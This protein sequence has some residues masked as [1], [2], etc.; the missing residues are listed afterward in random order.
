MRELCTGARC[1]NAGDDTLQA[2]NYYIIYRYSIE[3]PMPTAGR[4]RKAHGA[5]WKKFMCFHADSNVDDGCSISSPALSA[6]RGSSRSS[7][8]QSV[9][10]SSMTS[11]GSSSTDVNGS[12]RLF[13]LRSGRGSSEQEK[14]KT[15]KRGKG[16][17]N[18]KR[19]EEKDI[20]ELMAQSEED[21]AMAAYFGS[22]LAR[23]PSSVSVLTQA[24]HAAAIELA[25][26]SKASAKARSRGEEEEE[27]STGAVLTTASWEEDRDGSS[28]T[29][30]ESEDDGAVQRIHNRGASFCRV[31]TLSLVGDNDDLETF[32][33]TP[34]VETSKEIK[35]ES[36]YYDSFS[37]SHTDYS[38]S[39][40]ENEE[41]EENKVA[42]GKQK[43]L[44]LGTPPR[45]ERHNIVLPQTSDESG[46]YLSP[47]KDADKEETRRINTSKYDSN[48]HSD[49][50]DILNQN[51]D[52][53]NGPKLQHRTS[54]PPALMLGAKFAPSEQEHAAESCPKQCDMRNL[55]RSKTDVNCEL[56]FEKAYDIMADGR[57]HLVQQPVMR[58][59]ASIPSLSGRRHRVIIRRP[60]A[61]I[62]LS[63][64]SED[65]ETSKQNSWVKENGDVLSIR[66]S[67]RNLMVKSVQNTVSTKLNE[68]KMCELVSAKN[69]K[70]SKLSRKLSGVYQGHHV[71]LE[72]LRQ[73]MGDA[74]LP[75]N[76]LLSLMARRVF[77]SQGVMMGRVNSDGRVSM[78]DAQG[79]SMH[80]LS[81]DNPDSRD[82]AGPSSRQESG[83]MTPK[84]I[85]DPIEDVAHLNLPKIKTKMEMQ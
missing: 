41:S 5:A 85:D 34:P 46:A 48:A 35:L 69:P 39:T 40:H 20:G 55:R 62:I 54:A 11:R 59:N 76:D 3:V 56:F 32:A 70:A 65:D 66:S 2:T 23:E 4:G 71:R 50:G 7:N 17:N 68:Y 38:S 8:V 19:K 75:P 58:R 77:S 52:V 72:K 26:E 33:D 82:S 80:T 47:A 78:L 74:E 29:I 9:T 60:S 44:L 57:K 1:E 18:P 16:K 67:Y 36:G 83:Y 42:Y 22:G 28:L 6:T 84:S 53:Q 25:L 64:D 24:A 63:S 73:Q 43:S 31:T 14:T 10:V 81:P 49:E 61:V 30:G 79:S 13:S 27:S 45:T 12:R 15:K 37:A 51:S 21:E